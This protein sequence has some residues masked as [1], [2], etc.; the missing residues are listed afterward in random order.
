MP[1]RTTLLIIFLTLFTSALV[2]YSLML[3]AQKTSQADSAKTV[4][5][6][7]TP[8]PK[9]VSLSFNPT[10]FT[11]ASLSST[12][13][14]TNV[15]LN[16]PNNPVTSIQIELSYDPKVLMDVK[17][18]TP[19]SSLWQQT[20]A[21][22]QELYKNVD[23]VNGRISYIAS[24]KQNGQMISG[25]GPILS[26]SYKINRAA[27]NGSTSIKI[28]DKSLVM[29]NGT[30]KSVLGST[31]DFAILSVLPTKPFVHFAPITQASSSGLPATTTI[32]K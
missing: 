20:G 14:T 31:Q 26:I 27:L 7:I 13:G 17:L 30:N 2:V 32:P 22:Y 6:S 10:A 15:I 23:P 16:V 24:I 4:I 1:A 5:P 19:S 8:A 21:N 29:Q 25:N 9:N 12:S 3:N 11:V 28:L 18:A